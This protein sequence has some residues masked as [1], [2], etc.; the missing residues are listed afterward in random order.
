[1]TH[2]ELLA[3][4][5]VNALV[6]P[7]PLVDVVK[8]HSSITMDFTDS[9]FNQDPDHVNFV[10]F[11]TSCVDSEWPCKTI[12]VIQATIEELDLR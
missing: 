2:E 8:L 3:R 1:M 11:C 5:D 7:K 4:I 9:P 12:K 6:H 10:D